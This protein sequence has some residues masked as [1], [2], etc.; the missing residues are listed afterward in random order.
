MK[1][2]LDLFMN[3]ISEVFLRTNLQNILHLELPQTTPAN[4]RSADYMYDLLV[5]NGVDAERLNFVSD[6]KTVYHDEVMPLCWD[7]SIG[8]LTVMSEWDGDRV[9]A[10]YDKETFSLIRC[11]TATPEG[12]ITTKLV[13]WNDMLAG[14]DVNGALVLLP[15]GLFPTE[16]A[17]LPVLDRG[18]IGVV[19]G[20]VWKQDNYADTVH[21]ANNLTETNAWHVIEGERNF[22]G[23]CVTP[24]IH[25]KL[26]E[27]CEKGDVIVKAESDGKRY[28]G[29]MP[30]VTATIKG[31]SD[32]ELWVYAHIAEPLENDNN[33]GVM[34]SIAGIIAIKKAIDSGKIP[35]LKYTLRLCLSLERYGLVAFAHHFGD[36]LHS[37]CI[38][39][40][41]VDST[42]S[43]YSQTNCSIRLAAHGVPFFG[44]FVWQRVWEIYAEKKMPPFISSMGDYFGGDTFLSDTSVGLPTVTHLLNKDTGT[45]HNSS[46]RY[47]CVDYAQLRRV[48]AV[49]ATFMAVVTESDPEMLSVFMPTAASYSISRLASIATSHP[50]RKGT[51]EKARFDHFK[52][53]ELENLRA[54][55]DADVPQ[56]VIDNACAMVEDF[57]NRITVIPA[58]EAD[59]ETPIFDSFEKII[60]KRMC[61]GFPHDLG[62]IPLGIR[63]HELQAGIINRVFSAMDGTKNLKELVTEAEWDQKQTWSEIELKYFIETMELLKKYGYVEY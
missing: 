29:N 23:Y 49:N 37:R 60:P 17:L 51:D 36:I 5:K 33:D 30:A 7:A 19:N 58:T 1:K 45:W 2:Y 62:K 27:A 59:E 8:R 24:R 63:T 16:K 40:L 22:I 55:S 21:W 20:T 18:G 50:Q 10:D 44:N 12:G 31:K 15:S 9:V 41:C 35:P 26:E 61:V 25:R 56:D 3:G 48:S 47:N 42:P 4:H 32:R 6:G 39:G 43:S 38:G 54:F 34:A 52:N 28:A 11:S 13:K 46:Q 57:C 14:K 53:I